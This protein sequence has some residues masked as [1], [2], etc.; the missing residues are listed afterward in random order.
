MLVLTLPRDPLSYLWVSHFS[1]SPLFCLR[2][3]NLV[4][5]VFSVSG[6]VANLK[7]PVQLWTT[8][9]HCSPLTVFEWGDRLIGRF[10]IRTQG[11]IFP[12]E[13]SGSGPTGQVPH[14]YPV[15]VAAL[16]NRAWAYQGPNDLLV[17]GCPFRLPY[18]EVNTSWYLSLY[19]YSRVMLKILRYEGLG[20]DL[21]EWIPLC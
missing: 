6:M 19:W 17:F 5:N 18:A 14:F 7:H 11:F 2:V 9:A 13:I 1:I 3:G 15:I 21:S 16:F 4:A 20:T 8:E 12:W 10:Y